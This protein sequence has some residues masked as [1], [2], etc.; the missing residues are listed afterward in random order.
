MA[1]GVLDDPNRG[2]DCAP[3]VP[4]RRSFPESGALA[5]ARHFSRILSMLAN[6]VN[7]FPAISST[8]NRPRLISRR[9][10]LTVMPPAGNPKRTASASLRGV[11]NVIPLGTPSKARSSVAAGDREDSTFFL[12]NPARMSF[13]RWSYAVRLKASTFSPFDSDPAR[14]GLRLRLTPSVIGVQIAFRN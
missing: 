12:G 9:S 8:S 6:V 2:G 3:A 14:N 5:T 7:C 1:A 10:P 11:S 13:V 4:A